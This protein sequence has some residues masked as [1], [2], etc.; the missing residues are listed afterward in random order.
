MG[1]A[2]I[3]GCSRGIGRATAVELRRRGHEVVATARDVASLDGL[4]VDLRLPLDVVDDASVR[5]AVAAAGDV[6]ILVSNAGH[7]VQGPIE[8]VPVERARYLF[9]VHVF[10]GLRLLQ[11]VLPGMRERRSGVI[12][13]VSSASAQA[14][15]PILGF[16]SGVKKALEAMWEAASYE[17]ERFGVR[18]VIV[19]PGAVA[20]GF[21]EHRQ[22]FGEDSAYRELWDQWKAALG[23]SRGEPASA[24]SVATLIADCIENPDTP[25]RVFSGPDA[26][27]IAARRRAMDDQQY[28]A[29]LWENL[30]GRA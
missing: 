29:W 7:S 4:D 18:G 20:T 22:V 30:A 16:Y 17:V 11:A 9:D 28:R 19:E 25:L 23:R 14:T 13:A 6:D 21:P 12:V 26:E 5:E 10:G 15:R 24:E 1:R 2:L 27:R 3:T 8:T